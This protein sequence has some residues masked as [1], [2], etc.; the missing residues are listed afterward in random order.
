MSTVGS[1]TVWVQRM[2]LNLEGTE[3]DGY[4]VI[5]RL[6]DGAFTEI[7]LATAPTGVEV[8]IKALN[9]RLRDDHKVSDE[10]VLWHFEHEIQIM[11]RINHSHI[12]DLLKFG[13][14]KTPQGREFRYLVVKYMRGGTLQE[15]C[16]NASLNL[17][18]VFDLFAPLSD[19]L[20]RLHANGFIHCD[21]KPAN[22]LLDHSMR[23]T[24]IKLA[25]FS[26]SKSTR[27]ERDQVLVGTSPYAAPEHHPDATDWERSQP[28][29][30][31]ADVYALAMTILHALTGKKPDY[32]RRQIANLPPHPSYQ[33]L[34]GELS[35]VL[36]R[37]T[38]QEVARRHPSVGAFWEEFSAIGSTVGEQDDEVVTRVH[39]RVVINLEP[40]AS[41]DPVVGT[42]D[43]PEGIA[44]E[45]V[46]VPNGVFEMG[47]RES[48]IERLISC[49]PKYLQAQAREWLF[50]E[51]PIHRVKVNSFWMGK[52]PITRRQWSVV[53]TYLPQ[54]SLALPQNPTRRLPGPHSTDDDHPV[55]NVSWLEAW[56]FCARLS[57][58][59]EI[60]LPSEAEWEWACRAE[61]N[62][63]FNFMDL[64]NTRTINYNGVNPEL[65]QENYW[66]LD[67]KGT[68]PVGQVGKPNG[69]G[70]YDMH[71]NVMEWCADAWHENYKQAPRDGSVWGEGS[72]DLL[73]VARGGSWAVFS[74]MCRSASRSRF[75][76]NE[77]FDD[78]GFRIAI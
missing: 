45:I 43:L 29:D 51:F 56:E 38:H 28:L 54:Q 8:V 22:L 10:Q 77:Y 35:R 19:A 61:T 27:G 34:E 9:P 69:F 24:L 14:S 40:G 21:L 39:S 57:T 66:R 15:Y 37:A 33:G 4:S 60:R 1:P 42:I 75:L 3:I 62:T 17:Q 6:C 50:W 65:H 44:I 58:E 25:D 71:G 49:F 20:T 41:A 70:L 7:Y 26:V 76:Y 13:T 32:D 5:R 18:R 52:Y 16:R 63:L 72:N 53:A 59:K 31:R 74:S 30:E 78:I 68:R 2:R 55:T 67:K 23:P 64:V 12:V 36:G 47:T 11:S 73:R 46:Q 48:D